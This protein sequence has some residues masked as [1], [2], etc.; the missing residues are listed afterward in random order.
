MMYYLGQVRS[1]EPRD[2]KFATEV[3][4]SDRWLPFRSTGIHMCCFRSSKTLRMVFRVL[5]VLTVPEKRVVIRIHEGTNE[6]YC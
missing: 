3:A 6:G 4:L 5:S 2:P 1:Q